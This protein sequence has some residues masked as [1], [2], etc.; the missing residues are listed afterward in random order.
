[1]L[2]N[3]VAG[4]ETGPLEFQED[5]ILQFYTYEATQNI[6]TKVCFDHDLK[7]PFFVGGD[8][9]LN[10]RQW[11]LSSIR[12]PKETKKIFF[13][14]QNNGL[15]E[16]AV[17]ITD[18]KLFVPDSPSSTT[19]TTNACPNVPEDGVL[20]DTNSGARNGNVQNNANDAAAPLSAAK[21]GLPSRPRASRTK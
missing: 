4:I 18:V 11:K 5:R 2:R 6:H 10:D 20:Q 19:G 17:G 1:L 3:D 14:S 8:V 21:S 9:Q 15:N 7:C 13:I 12:V 16:G